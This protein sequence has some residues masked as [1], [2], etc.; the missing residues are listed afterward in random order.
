MLRTAK[1]LSQ[2]F[3]RGKRFSHTKSNVVLMGAPGSG[4]SSVGRVLSK[5]LGKKLIDIDDDYLEPLWGKSVAAQLKQL[6]DEGFLKAESEALLKFK[7]KGM[8]VSLTG[9]VPLVQESM[10][11][12]A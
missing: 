1:K 8:V 10:K 3:S 9:S 7:E 4:K 5:L 2:Q 6:G 11:H 12:M